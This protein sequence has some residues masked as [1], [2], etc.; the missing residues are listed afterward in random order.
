MILTVS[1]RWKALKPRERMVL[2]ALGII[3]LLTVL[4][5]GR[6]LP[7]LQTVAETNAKRSQAQSQW[8]QMQQLQQ[9][10][11][12]LEAAPLVQVRQAE[13]RLQQLTQAAGSGWKI[14]IQGGQA[15]LFLQGVSAHALAQ[16]LAQAREQTLAL[17]IEAEL[18]RDNSPE[19]LWSG[20]IRLQWPRPGAAP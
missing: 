10:A 2:K 14:Q 6:V 8:A 20:R 16:W 4:V 3:L 17:P 7:A 11:K 13:Q 9:Q 5:V 19:I 18:T 15:D 1:A 12:T